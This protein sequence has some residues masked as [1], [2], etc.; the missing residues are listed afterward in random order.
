VSEGMASQL[1]KE[2]DQAIAGVV[3]GIGKFIKKVFYGLKK[4][5]ALKF[6]LGLLLTVGMSFLV[7]IFRP[8]LFLQLEKLEMPRMLQRVIYIVLFF[9]PLIYL[10]VIGSTGERN[11]EAFYKIFKTIE[12]KGRDGKYPYYLKMYQDEAK[13]TVYLFKTSINLGEWKK[14]QERLEVA[15]DCTILQI[16]NKGSK[17]LIEITALSSDY[18][19][20]EMVMWDDEFSPEKESC[21]VVGMGVMGQVSFDLDSTPH[22][23]VA[24]ETG[25]GKSVIL[26]VCLWQMIMKGAR[27]VML[28]FKGGVEFG[29][30]YEQY[31]EVI[32]ERERASEV[33]EELVKENALRLALFRNSRVKNITEYNSKTNSHLCRIGVFCDEIAEM[34]DTT[35]VPKKEREIYEKIKALLSTLARLSRSTG[36]NLV[37]GVQRPDANV[38]TGQIKNNI[39]VRICGRFADKAASEIVLNSTA[40]TG[41]PEIKGRFLFLRGNELIEFQAYLFKDSMLTDICVD[42]GSMLMEQKKEGT[43]K[44]Q[45]YEKPPVYDQEEEHKTVADYGLDRYQELDTNFDYGDIGDD[46]LIDWSVDK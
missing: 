4:L 2:V 6:L 3:F 33:L 31:G 9:N 26:H 13:R 17:K 19:L 12:F 44:L 37:M 25:S 11:V 35:G 15:L 27:V 7:Y 41:L 16:V 22:V 36:I 20:P 29:L 40:A 23:L 42:K 14:N 30:E 39:P 21:L 10:A 43:K 32:T 24:G 1:D 28:D 38:L 46:G 8:L 34:M 45:Y 18:K 5:K